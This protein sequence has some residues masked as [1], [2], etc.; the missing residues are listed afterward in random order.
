MEIRL[1]EIKR[2]KRPLQARGREEMSEQTLFVTLAR[3]R[4]EWLAQGLFIRAV[5]ME[6]NV[7]KFLLKGLKLDVSPDT[8]P[9]VHAEVLTKTRWR[10]DVEI[11]WPNVAPIHF[12]LKLTAPF[13][14]RQKEAGKKGQLP[15]LIVPRR[16][17]YAKLA[18][19]GCIFEWRE[20]AAQVRQDARVKTLLEEVSV[21]SSW[22][23]DELKEDALSNEFSQFNSPKGIRRWPTLFRFL[24]TVDIYILEMRGGMYCSS[25]QLSQTSKAATPYYGYK[26][27][28]GQVATP[29]YWVG[30]WR[31]KHD[32]VRF[33]LWAYNGYGYQQGELLTDSLPFQARIAAKLIVEQSEAYRA[34]CVRDSP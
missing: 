20:L 6:P 15:A 32:T 22:L 11:C 14:Q 13:T 25:R 8:K 4:P 34:R 12:E 1:S 28:L 24:C 31:N 18:S 27:H 19:N 33:G 17:H 3:N 5:A 7:R 23:T 29:H 10:A 16:E 30:F 26:F 21:S 2:L 9:E